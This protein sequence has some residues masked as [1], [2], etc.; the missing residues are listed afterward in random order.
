M[1]SMTVRDLEQVQSALAEAGLDYRVELEQGKLEVVGPSDIISSEIGAELIRILGNWV[2]PR[3]LGRVFD[4]A[5]GF[6]LSN[7]DLK[8]PDVAFVRAARLKQS[9]RYFGQLTPDLVVEIKSQSDRLSVLKAKLDRFLA[10]GAQV[11]ILIDPDEQTVTVYRVAEE[12]VVLGSEDVL[13]L[14][15][16]LPGWEC[17]VNTLWPPVFEENDG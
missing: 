16:L 14:P 2:R 17:P 1:A 7:R 4:S 15:D 3:R 8:A 6:I 10:E 5:R 12:Q 13:T 11:G 9:V